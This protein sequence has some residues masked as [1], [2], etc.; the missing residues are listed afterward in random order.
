M[1]SPEFLQRHRGGSGAVICIN[2]QRKGYVP[3]VAIFSCI[4]TAEEWTRAQPDQENT[5]FTF[6]P[7]IVDDPDWLDTQPGLDKL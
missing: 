2:V 5:H 1:P 7:M 6:F 3:R 4:D